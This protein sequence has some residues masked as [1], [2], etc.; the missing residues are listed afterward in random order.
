MPKLATSN[1]GIVLD[2]KAAQAILASL[3]FQIVAWRAKTEE[4]LGDD[5]YADL[6]HDILY[7]ETLLA[8]LEA[9]FTEA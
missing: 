2:H 4:E 9:D 3:R 7:L 5:A 8:T 1:D 6:G